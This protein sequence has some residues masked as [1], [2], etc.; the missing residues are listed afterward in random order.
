[1]LFRSVVSGD[2]VSIAYDLS[3]TVIDAVNEGGC[4]PEDAEFQPGGNGQANPTDLGWDG[5]FQENY[6]YRGSVCNGD[7]DWFTFDA[8]DDNGNDG[9]AVELIVAGLVGDG[10]VEL[11]SQARINIGIAVADYTTGPGAIT[12]QGTTRYT[13]DVP[14]DT[15]GLAQGKWYIRLRGR[16]PADILDDYALNITLLPPGGACV[17]DTAEPNGGPL[18][19]APNDANFDLAAGVTANGHL[20]TGADLQ[21]PTEFSLC[22]GEEDWYSFTAND[23]DQIT[24]WATSPNLAGTATIEITNG[25]GNAVGQGGNLTDEIGRAHV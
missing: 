18:A 8:A 11:Y 7:E 16:T 9:I 2:P 20:R 19:A 4:F 1:M 13:I 12:P 3:V 5:R 17:I 24:A 14:R 21:I 23:G 10:V 22:A 25:Q 6:S 15:A